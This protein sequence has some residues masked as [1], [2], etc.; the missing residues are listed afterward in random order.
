MRGLFSLCAAALIGAGGVGRADVVL[1]AILSDHMVLEKSK[2]TVIWGK[3]APEEKVSVALAG[4][5]ATVKTDTGGKWRTTLD[6]SQAAA[7]PHEMVVKGKNEIRVR[8]VMVG[9]VWLA[10]GQSNMQFVLRGALGDEEEMAAPVNPMLRHFKVKVTPSLDPMDDCEGEWEV[11][12]P[13]TLGNF[14]AVGYFFAKALQKELGSPIGVIN[15]TLGGTAAESWTSGDGM[16]KEPEL[17]DVAAAQWKEARGYPEAKQKWEEAFAEWTKTVDRPD[18]RSGNAGEFAAVNADLTAWK[19]LKLPGTVAGAVPGARWFRRTVEVPAQRVGKNLFLVLGEIEGFEEIYWNGELIGSLTPANH[20]GAPY[21]RRYDVPGNMVKA[22][23]NVLA[24][25]VFSPATAGG[26]TGRVFK[27]GTASLMGEWLTRVEYEFP[28]PPSVPPPLQPPGPRSPTGVASSLFNGMINPILPLTIKGVIWYQGEGNASRAWQY[29][30]TFPLLIQDWREK[31]GRPALPFYFCQLANHGK[32]MSEPVDENWAELREAQ[33]LAL[34][35]PHTG[36]A[37]LIDLGEGEA[38]HPVNKKDVG[39]R[40]AKIALA[41]TY[42]KN[43]PFSGPV[44][45]SSVVEADKIR[46]RFTHTD[47]GL[48]ARPLPEKHDLFIPDNRT[49]PLVRNSPGSELE[50]FAISGKDG[51]WVWA[52]ARIDGTEVVVWS[53]KVPAPAAVRYAWADNPTANLYNGAGLPATPFRTDDFP[54]VTKTRK[55]QP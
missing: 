46:I 55:Y 45:A 14:T 44:L 35:L 31:W 24:I 47:G 16:L 23:P 29:R 40:L 32:K 19:P 7:G 48:V 30:K 42:G 5:T 6:L 33:S 3:A 26:L 13:T 28:G 18:R 11:A 53:E 9:D 54:L 36:Q 17:A 20:P 22:G 38:I 39:D 8:D 12:G 21:A 34:S 41:K 10:S 49:A 43:I 1:P 51:K 52:E 50:G 37:L 4:Q 2:S 27:A 15:A 25:R